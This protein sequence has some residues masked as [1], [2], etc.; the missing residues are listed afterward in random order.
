MATISETTRK[1][2]SHHI[3]PIPAQRLA[4]G[5]DPGDGTRGP[6]SGH[7]LVTR[8]RRTS[9]AQAARSASLT[10][11]GGTAFPPVSRPSIAP[12]RRSGHWSNRPSPPSSPGGS[13]A[14]SDARRPGSRAS[15]KLSSPSIWPAQTEVGKGSV[16]RSTAARRLSSSRRWVCHPEAKVE[17]SAA[18]GGGR[19]LSAPCVR[20]QQPEGRA[21]PVIASRCVVNPETGRKGI[22][23]RP[24]PRRT[25]YVN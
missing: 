18:G 16:K 3:C 9:R 4:S 7:H 15:S 21:G 6:H 8:S 20:Q 1:P 5:H 22:P 25:G 13:S 2:A 11:A 12:M 17:P 10:A 19:Q 23:V 14:S 24:L